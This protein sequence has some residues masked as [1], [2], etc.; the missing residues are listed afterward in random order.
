M[1]V[2]CLRR[3]WAGRRTSGGSV[4]A[5]CPEV[6]EGTC[7]NHYSKCRRGRREDGEHNYPFWVKFC[8]KA[9][10][11]SGPDCKKA[12]MQATVNSGIEV[13]VFTPN[14]ENIPGAIVDIGSVFFCF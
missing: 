3:L 8:F 14:K 9:T 5:I 2:I 13:P 6:E 4:A 7:Q 12:K 1:S 10:L 11:D